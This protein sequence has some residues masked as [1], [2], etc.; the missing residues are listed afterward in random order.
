[1]IYHYEPSGSA[2]GY[3]YYGSEPLYNGLTGNLMQ[4]DI[5]MGVVYYQRLRLVTLGCDGLG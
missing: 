1:M 4:A 5:F 3:Q 2:V